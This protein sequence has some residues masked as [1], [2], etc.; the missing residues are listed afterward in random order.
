MKKEL[1][2]R[3]TRQGVEILS[4]EDKGFHLKFRD[5]KDLVKKATQED[6]NAAQRHILIHRRLRINRNCSILLNRCF[7]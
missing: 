6:Y 4:G 7:M 2:A 1:V 3:A 5:Q